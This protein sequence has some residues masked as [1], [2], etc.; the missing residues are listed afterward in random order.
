NAYD[1]AL[2]LQTT[3]IAEFPGKPDLKKD[4]A[5]TYYNLGILYKDTG[6]QQQAQKALEDA[7]AILD[8]LA[9]AYPEKLVYRQ[10]LGRAYLNLA[11]VMERTA[12]FE[13][14]LVISQKAI[15]T[16]R[17]LITL[18]PQAPDYQQ[19]LA[20]CYNNLGNAYA[21]AG[22]MAKAETNY[23]DAR[24]LFKRLANDFP[25]IPVY[26]IELANT[27][28][29]LAVVLAR[30]K[31]PDDAFA[32]W[33]DNE[34]IQRQL[35]EEYKQVP[36]YRGDLGMTRASLG[37]VYLTRKELG[38]AKTYLLAAT[39]DLEYALATNPNQPDYLN[40][41]KFAYVNLGYALVGLNE[42]AAAFQHANRL[43]E[44]FP[45][46]DQGLVVALCFLASCFESAKLQPSDTVQRADEF[47]VHAERI[48][49]AAL[50]AGRAKALEKLGNDSNFAALRDHAS[51]SPLLLPKMP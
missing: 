7:V 6:K 35:V 9:R 16:F 11:P 44:S 46:R 45:H 42:D 47:A 24:A 1:R 49:Q 10:H 30:S 21:R 39:A 17:L 32:I 26:R 34:N 36:S 4:L 48:I 28:N 18:N 43:V 19:E 50:S 3:L 8:E 2:Q 14:A 38:K 15:E 40:A 5:R 22:D 41:A 12:G 23:T 51:I 37:R 29:S 20:V 13:Q 27:H 33:K 31:R 25:N